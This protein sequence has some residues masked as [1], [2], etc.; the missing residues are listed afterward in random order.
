MDGSGDWGD[1]YAKAQAFVKQLTLLEKVNLTTGVGWKGE[2]CVGNTGS[3]PRLGFQGICFQD[4]PLGVRFGDYV[5]TFPAGG[6]VAASFDRE[7]WYERGRRVALEQSDKGVD[8]QLGPAIGPLGRHPASGRVWEGFSPD[9]YLSGVAVA[10]TIKGMQDAGVIAVTK[11]FIGNEQENFRQAPEA[12]SYGFNVSE[13]LS[14]NIDDTTL[15][16]LYLWPFADAVRAGTGS[17][18]CS[19]TQVNNSY[20]CQ[21][22]YVMNGILKTELGFQ[23][24]VVTDWSGQHSGVSSA[25]AGLDVAMPGDTDFGSGYA[26]WGPNLTLAV[27]NG[28]IPEWRVDDMATRLMAA[29]YYVGRDKLQRPVN[30]NSWSKDTYGWQNAISDRNW[31]LINQHVDVRRDNTAFIR[32]AAARSVVLLKNEGAL[33]LSGHERFT[34]VFGS[35]ADNNPL[36]PNA[37]DDRGC[38][39]GTLASGWGSGTSDFPF[40]VSPL[41]AIQ[42]EVVSKNGGLIQS[43]TDDYAYE[44]VTALAARASHCLTFVNADAGEG[45]ISVD[46]NHGDRNNLTLWH[47]GNTLIDTVA[48]SCNNTIVII[49]GPSAVQVDTFADHPNVTAILWAGFPGEQSGNAIADVLYGRVN[50]A[51]RTPFTWA[52]DVTV[53]YGTDI[54]YY[55]N[56]NATGVPQQDFTEGIFIDYR[57]FDAANITP[58]YE[59]GHGLSYT[60]F[61]YANLSITKHADAPPY[62]PNNRSIADGAPPPVLGN[63]S[64]NLDDYLF[65]TDGSVVRVPGYIY[66][67]LNDTDASA[68][69]AAATTNNSSPTPQPPAPAGGAPGGNPRLWDVLF[70]VRA[71]VTNTGNVAGDEVA[72][73]YVSLG[74]ERNAPKVLR[75]FDRLADIQPGESV[76]FKAELTRRDVSNWDAGTQDWVVTADEKRVFVGPSSRVVGVEGVLD[77]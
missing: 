35:D 51:G 46:G 65:P 36:G 75:G 32:E 29:F 47:D 48:S 60:T 64:T 59:F 66:P 50:P 33:P 43:V 34:A 40:L 71:T 63:H 5:S 68:A 52:R 18:M 61:A 13:S 58:V 2:G 73:L 22:S 17:V 54:L 53:D 27:V 11:H 55:P 72:Q 6:T 20:G 26:F 74:G 37:C 56:N 25:L 39:E 4:G 45:Y 14:S 70:T 12:L 24:F 10:E 23:G 9:P 57:H 8:V 44:Q 69:T 3:I 1:A 62:A 7:L 28:S 49:H 16:E 41:T 76:E 21:N 77:L 67:W 31:G 30:F 19:Y 15:H 38:D 42:N